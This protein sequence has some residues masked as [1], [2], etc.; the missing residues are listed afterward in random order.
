MLLDDFGHPAP[1]PGQVRPLLSLAPMWRFKMSKILTALLL[2]TLLVCATSCG[3][4]ASDDSPLDGAT[5]AGFFNTTCPV[6]GEPVEADGGESMFQDHKIGFCC[7]KCAGK[8]DSMSDAE[9][10]AALAKVG[11]KL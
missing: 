11:T 9:K 1:E 2:G 5:A 3:S 10:V 4:A 7:G 6:G 8:F